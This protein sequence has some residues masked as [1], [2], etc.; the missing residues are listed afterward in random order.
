[1]IIKPTMVASTGPG[2]AR[3]TESKKCYKSLLYDI[4][5]IRNKLSLV[6]KSLR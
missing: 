4:I 6:G 2:E 3:L 1:M 5:K